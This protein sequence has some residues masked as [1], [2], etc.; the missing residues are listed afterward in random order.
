MN[1][2]K[3]IN[4]SIETILKEYSDKTGLD[5]SYHL[6]DVELDNVEN[7]I[8]DRIDNNRVLDVEVIY[9]SVAIQ[10]LAENDPSLAESME[11]A[12]EYGYTTENLNSE[13]L[14]SLLASREASE[15][16][17]EY[18]D[19]LIEDLEEVNEQ[20]LEHLEEEE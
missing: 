14:A 12:N 15:K 16:F 10:Y 1:Y 4:D 17:Y 7:W 19:Q 13:L 5:L 11:I 6:S 20:Y 8:D 2:P 9:Y 3:F 18:R